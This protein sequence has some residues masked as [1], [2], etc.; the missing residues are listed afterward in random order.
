VDDVVLHRWLV[1]APAQDLAV[2]TR[3][4]GV[5]RVHVSVGDFA[6][7]TVLLGNP[8]AA[9]SAWRPEPGEHTPTLSAAD[10]YEQRWMFHGPGFQA[11][12]ACRA[13]A[14]RS[15]RADLTVPDAPGA[16]LD[17]VGQVLGLWLIEREERWVAFPVRIARIRFHTAEPSPGTRLEC[18]VRIRDIAPDAVEAEAQLTVSGRVVV[19]ISGWHDRR[20]DGGGR[21]GDIHRF[22]QLSTLSEH[23][24][25]GWWLLA[26]PWRGIAARELSLH[27]YLGAAELDRILKEEVAAL[28]T[29]TNAEELGDFDLPELPKPYVLLVVGV[30]GVGKTTTIGK[31]ASQYKR[32]GKSVL[33]GAAD[34]FRAAAVEQLELWGVR[35]GVR[36][37]SKGANTDPSAVA[38]ETVKEGLEKGMDVVII[39]TAGRLHT[40]VNL[41][42]ELTKIKRVIQKVIPDAPHDV[43]LV[44]D[45]STGQ[46]A[47]IQ[48]REFTKAT[49]V[50]CLAI[51]K[52]DGTAKG[53]VVIGISDEFK[54]PVRFIGVGEKIEDL[55]VFNKMEFVDSLFQ[56]PG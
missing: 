21:L 9:P 16:L 28:L 12:S 22:P 1:A 15:A 40:K 32:K 26:D 54:I 50:T 19:S 11:V 25:G 44:L 39:D 48:A 3:P 52:L 56:K 33:L 6:E 4:V 27:K 45:G 46:N 29:E 51:T 55:Q 53:G 18:T 10:L 23:Q 42:Q 20:F 24:P 47:S 49:E 2:R 13:V 8:E 7:A 5:D 37:I 14:D 30:N 41:M 43:M 31:L 34:T 35:A 36:V 17:G 38:Y